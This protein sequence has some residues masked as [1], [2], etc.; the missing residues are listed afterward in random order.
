MAV[1]LEG[2][3]RDLLPEFLA[4]ALVLLGPLQTAGAVSSGALQAIFYDLDHLLV[5]IQTHSHADGTVR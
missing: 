4:D 5:L 1:A 3:I 2:R